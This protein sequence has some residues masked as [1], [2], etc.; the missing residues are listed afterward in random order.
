MRCHIFKRVEVLHEITDSFLCWI[1]IGS[2]MNFD[3]LHAWKQKHINDHYRFL[4]NMT[5][6]K[7]RLK[8][9]IEPGWGQCVR[10][11]GG[12]H[13]EQG[14]EVHLLKRFSVQEKNNKPMCLRDHRN[15][16]VLSQMGAFI[17]YKFPKLV[18][19]ILTKDSLGG[20]GGGGGE[21]RWVT[22]F[23]AQVSWYLIWWF[24]SLEN[25]SGHTWH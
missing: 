9:V 8:L 1:C 19:V 14:T 25:R 18:C 7:K 24:A 2:L 15:G 3:S 11:N 21:M 17:Q 4:S 10:W 22:R 5:E 16:R 6:L 12:W 23:T 20:G 13:S